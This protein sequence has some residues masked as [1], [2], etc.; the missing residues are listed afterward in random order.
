MNENK[1]FVEKKNF[2]FPVKKSFP[3]F[4]P[5]PPPPFCITFLFLCEITDRTK[6]AKI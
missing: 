6:D 5:P 3:F 1:K 4:P 2:L